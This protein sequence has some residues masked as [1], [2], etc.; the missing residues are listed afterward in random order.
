MTSIPT[1]LAELRQRLILETLIVT[2]NEVGGV[3]RMWQNAATLWASIET[4]EADQRADTGQVG[5]RLTHRVTIRYRPDI[6]TLK[7]F[8]RDDDIFMIRAVYDANGRRRWL[9]CLCEELR[10]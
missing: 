8:R 3:R 1:S 2:S 7:R 10:P 4:I 6:D 5:Q 9:I